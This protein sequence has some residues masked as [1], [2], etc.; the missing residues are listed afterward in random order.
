MD[1]S[2]RTRAFTVS[3]VQVE[4]LHK[5]EFTQDELN[6]LYSLLDGVYIPKGRE[7]LPSMPLCAFVAGLRKLIAPVAYVSIPSAF[8][9]QIAALKA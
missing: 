3:T 2:T 6:K 4:T 7:L 5:L 8:G 1:I 9:G